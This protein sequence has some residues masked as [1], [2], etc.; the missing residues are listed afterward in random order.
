MYIKKIKST[1]GIKETLWVDF[2]Y[3]GERY[4]KPLKLDNTAKNRKIAETKIIPQLQLKVLSGEFFE[5]SMPTISEY[6]VKSFDLHRLHRRETTNNDYQNSFKK[7]L[8]PVFGNKKLDAIKPSDITIFQNDLITKYNLSPKRVK[9]IRGILSVI[10]EDAIQDEIVDKNPVR[11]SGRLPIHK[12]R[13]VEP[14]DIEEINK[15][16]ATA[17]GLYKNFYAISFFTGIRTGELIGLRCEDVDIKARE[18]KIRRTIGRGHITEPKTQSSIRTVE[19]IDVVIPYF[20][21]QLKLTAHLDDYLFL[22]RN[23]NHFFDSKNIRDKNWKSTLLKAGIKYRTLYQ[24]RHSF[25]TMMISGG[26]DII[27]V[28]SM[29]GH[30]TPKMTLEKYSKYIKSKTKKRGVFL[31]GNIVTE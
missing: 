23:G 10:Y 6:S 20:I 29:M 21:N 15:I 25:A 24:T 18:F 16:L 1:S 19:M 11:R 9:M 14:F 3:N 30:T 12:Q 17:T 8:E 4:R 31:D 26:E 7:Y 13:E 28:S 5:S 2:T 22:N 27:W